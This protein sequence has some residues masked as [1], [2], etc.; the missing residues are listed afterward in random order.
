MS[1]QQKFFKKYKIYE[2]DEQKISTQWTW[3]N[4][5]KL[6]KYNKIVNLQYLNAI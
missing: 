2:L 6:G 3:I 5:L 4:K 1:S